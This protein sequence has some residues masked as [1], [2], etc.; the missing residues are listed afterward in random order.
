M[1]PKATIVANWRFQLGEGLHWDAERRLLWLVDILGKEIRW[2]DPASADTGSVTLPETVGWVLSVSGSTKVVVGLQSGIALCE[3][4]ERGSPI[5]WLDRR[6]PGDAGLRLI[7]AKIDKFGRI[8]YGSVSMSNTSEPLASLARYDPGG[9]TGTVI[10]DSYVVPNGPA[11][12]RDC[13]VMLHTDSAR[14]VVYAYGLNAVTGLVQKRSIW[15]RFLEADGLP[16]GMTFDADG[17]VWIAHWGGGRVC[18]Y[19]PEGDLLLTVDMP[20]PHVTNVCFAG[21]N[22]D[23][24]FVTS[25]RHGRSATGDPAAGAL[26]E[27]LGVDVRGLPPWTLTL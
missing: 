5:E 15:R 21:V 8:W 24:V 14:R 1:K 16:D 13:T 19:S 2:Y 20:T 22:L 23:R 11:F 12:N 18:R 17:C 26:F 3:P 9:G 25:A 27:I 7:D 6:F 10:D 4:F